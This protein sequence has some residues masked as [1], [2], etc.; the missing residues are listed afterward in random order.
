VPEASL[1]PSRLRERPSIDGTQ[2]GV[3]NPGIP[4]T[5]IGGPSCE[6]ASSIVWW[7]VRYGG[8][9]GWTAEGVLPDDY[10]IDPIGPVATPTDRPIGA[11]A[12]TATGIVPPERTAITLETVA[13]LTAV[14]RITGTDAIGGVNALA[15]ASDTRFIAVGAGSGV[16][17]YALPVLT[18]ALTQSTLSDDVRA[19]A[20]SADGS[21]FFYLTADGQVR[22][23]SGQ[24][25]RPLPA[26]S[27]VLGGASVPV[28]GP[29]ALTLSPDGARTAVTGVLEDGRP[30]IVLGSAGSGGTLGEI[31]TDGPARF[32]R[33]SPTGAL[34]AYAD[35]ELHIADSV[36]R[37]RYRQ[38]LPAEGLFAW[39]PAP[40]DATGA[41]WVWGNEEQLALY[42]LA[43]VNTPVAGALPQLQLYDLEQPDAAAI[44][45]AALA[46]NAGGDVLAV[47]VR[48]LAQPGA[49]GDAAQPVRI[50][51][52]G[53]DTGDLITT[54]DATGLTAMAFSPDGTLF[55][56]AARD[57]VTLYTVP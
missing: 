33:F 37:E 11:D 39:R 34:L 4:F 30:G 54:L 1:T 15:F 57:G 26:Q 44:E 20:F 14:T 51:L 19:L 45:T 2:I 50:L 27:A 46:F 53:T 8:L 5:I 31:A 56:T 55:A 23:W 6:V 18:P 29:E 49:P 9:T 43:D 22:G 13:S 25:T 21:A 41:A 12:V 28:F 47:A 16:F 32:V 52:F 35:R 40:A 38:A 24:A 3:I 48:V 17:A 10:F 7:Q 36:G 42:A